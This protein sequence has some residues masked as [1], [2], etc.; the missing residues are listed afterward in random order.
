MLGRDGSGVPIQI[1]GM[2]IPTNI[3]ITVYIKYIGN[4]M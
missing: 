1:Y 2:Q 3:K 4:M